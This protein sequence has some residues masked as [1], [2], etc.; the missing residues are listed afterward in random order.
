MQHY[1]DDHGDATLAHLAVAVSRAG[2][3]ASRSHRNEMHSHSSAQ[4]FEPYCV[5]TIDH[6]IITVEG[7][8]KR[9]LML[10]VYV[11][12]HM[13]TRICVYVLST[14]IF[15]YFSIHVN[16]L[17]KTH[18]IMHSLV[19]FIHLSIHMVHCVNN[20]IIRLQLWLLELSVGE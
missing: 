3:A 13:C 2:T 10:G 7:E 6:S 8:E 20:Y 12:N 5:T 18:L 11:Y 1:V 14:L 15:P 19:P 17:K 4:Y 9:L 16:V